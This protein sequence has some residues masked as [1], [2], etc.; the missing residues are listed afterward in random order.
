MDGRDGTEIE[1]SIRGP[2]GPKKISNLDFTFSCI[3]VDKLYLAHSQEAVLVPEKKNS[4]HQFR[5]CD[6]I[7]LS[8]KK[9]TRASIRTLFFWRFL[10]PDLQLV[11]NGRLNNVK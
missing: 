11:S 5:F 10:V 2:R 6:R 8:S 3:L 7:I 1:G 9:N 4:I